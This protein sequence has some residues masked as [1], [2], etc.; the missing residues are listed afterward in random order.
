MAGVRKGNRLTDWAPLI[1]N[2]VE[3]LSE[4]TKAGLEVPHD[5]ASAVWKFVIVNIAI[6]WHHAPIDALIPHIVPL[7]QSLSREP[8]MKWFIPFCSYF[9]GLD[10][11]RF[12][13]LF[14]NDFQR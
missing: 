2:F 9:C 10:A 12:G 4:V 5:A 6:V 13:S 1:K 3:L 7:T 8:F 11:Q 14:R